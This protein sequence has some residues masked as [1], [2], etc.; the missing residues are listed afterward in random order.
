MKAPTL[1]AVWTMAFPEQLAR[2][3]KA[4][5]MTQQQLADLAKL[6]VVQIRRYEGG[7]SQ[8]A[9]DIL[10][11]LA[12]AL[13]VSAD[14]LLFDETER[15][16]SGD[17]ALQFEAVSHLPEPEQQVARTLLDAMIFKHRVNALTQPRPAADP[18]AAKGKSSTGTHKQA[19]R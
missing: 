19:S 6:H 5:G 15:S 10:K 18:S 4:R 14:A 3:R 17:L 16:P 7:I 9:V 11:R 8:P 12:V 1:M 13:S 2:L